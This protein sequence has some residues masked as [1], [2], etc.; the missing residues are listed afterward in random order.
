MIATLATLLATMATGAVGNNATSLVSWPIV[1]RLAAV[2]LCQYVSPARELV[3]GPDISLNIVLVPSASISTLTAFP[4]ERLYLQLRH[5]RTE[6][7]N[8]S[9]PNLVIPLHDL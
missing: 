3:F 4:F 1:L 5:L 6:R 2:D 9:S 7:A 8:T